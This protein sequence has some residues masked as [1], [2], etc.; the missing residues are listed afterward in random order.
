V[1][2]AKLTDFDAINLVWDAWIV[3]G[4]PPARSPVLGPLLRPDVFVA[5]E[6]IVAIG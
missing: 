3:P 2:F 1:F 4:Q 5:A 6:A